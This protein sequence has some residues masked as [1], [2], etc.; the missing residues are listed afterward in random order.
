MS[1]SITANVGSFG[2]VTGFAKG[3]VAEFR[4]IPF[5]TVPVRF[6]RAEPLT[7]LPGGTLDATKY[8]P[9]PA[10]APIDNEGEEYLFGEYVRTFFAEDSKRTLS[11]RDCLNLNIV[12]PIDALGKKKLPVMVW[13]YGFPFGELRLT[14]RWCF[15]DGW[16]FKGILQ[17]MQP[18]RA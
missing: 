12:A 10:Q 2:K 13:I 7:T 1:Q 8:G 11:E 15:R 18:S 9:S 17:W 14:L 5:A 16:Q 4:G 3:N 6:R